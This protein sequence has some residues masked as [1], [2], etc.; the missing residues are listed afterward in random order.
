MQFDAWTVFVDFSLMAALLL[1]GQVLRAK[2]KL[3]QKLLIP[4]ALIAG[5]IGLALGPN[6]YQVLPLSTSLGKYASILIVLVFAAMPI[7]DRPSK[8]QLSSA[9]VGGM[10]T[11]VTGIAIAQYGFGMAFALYVLNLIWR[12]HP[13]FGLMLATGFYGG[14]G[15]AAAVG[16]TYKGL[17]WEDALG[18]GMT[19]ATVGIVGGIVFG[20]A[21]INWGTRKG[22][23]HYVTS[24]EDL[25][26][27]LRTGL[28]PPEKQ[29]VGGKVTVSSISVD[30]LA[31][32]VGLILLPSVVGYYAAEYMKVLVPSLT[33]PAFC[34]S[35]V[36]AFILQY[37]L[38]KS[39]AIDYVDRSTISRISGTATDFLIIAGT[40]SIKLSLL[41]EYW[42]PLLLLFTFGFLINLLWFFCV[43]KYSSP[44][45][46]FERNMMV[47]GHATGV[48]ATG[49]LL[50]RIVDPD[51]KSRGVEDSGI[52]DI[53]NR[54]II[55]ALQVVPPLVISW[56]GMWPHI[57]TWV[58][59]GATLL[60]LVIA[61][62][63]GWWKPG[64][65]P[66][67]YRKV[68]PQVAGK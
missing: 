3:F 21:I 1:L 6:G 61:K 15:T 58:I 59:I 67:A 57:T 26:Q 66:Q 56:G 40:A 44:T 62:V 30:P 55:I 17:G 31:F 52:A 45:D 14:H 29:K 23:T 19:S 47:W 35:L 10:F 25:P 33:I 50:Q 36:F 41:A 28:I 53:I 20:V 24:P 46:W 9:A 48:V 39:D 37:F 51:F 13:G 8:Q 49:V 4:A 22:Y 68:T 60:L 54:P 38:V 43:G 7:G 2:V 12:L 34:M 65:N 5:F 64:I 18:L 11:N 32:H 27:E 63:C 42:A 16:S